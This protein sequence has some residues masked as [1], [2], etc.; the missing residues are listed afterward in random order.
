MMLV[1]LDYTKWVAVC[2]YPG[3]YPAGRCLPVIRARAEEYSVC[4][5]E[6]SAAVRA[7]FKARC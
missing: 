7:D 4:H 1:G 5:N 6:V 2:A 3:N